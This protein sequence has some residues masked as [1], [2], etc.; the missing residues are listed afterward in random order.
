MDQPLNNGHLVFLHDAERLDSWQDHSLLQVIFMNCIFLLFLF[1]LLYFP[2]LV[3]FFHS[4]LRQT[5]IVSL[6]T[7][8]VRCAQA[9]TVC[10]LSKHQ[11]VGEEPPA[12]P[13]FRKS[14]CCRCWPDSSAG[15]THSFLFQACFNSHSHLLDSELPLPMPAGQRRQRSGVR[16]QGSPGSSAT[17]PR[18]TWSRC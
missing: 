11:R 8:N 2:V 17:A 16:G 7:E 10:I 18:Q 15:I 14:S 9:A 5:E 1:N 6:E 4:F 12:G 3:L 13:G